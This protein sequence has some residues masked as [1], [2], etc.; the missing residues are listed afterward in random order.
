M[1]IDV[2]HDE[3]DQGYPHPASLCVVLLGEYVVEKATRA[4]LSSR[5]SNGSI[6]PPP[7]KAVGPIPLLIPVE[8]LRVNEVVYFGA[9]VS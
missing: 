8:G 9:A 6:M 5:K 7:G 1:L 2:A 3:L 4:C